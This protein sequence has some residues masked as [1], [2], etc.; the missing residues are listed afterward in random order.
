M[1][2]PFLAYKVLAAGAIH[3]IDGFKYA[4]VNGADFISVGMYDFQVR[5]DVNVTKKLFADK[6]PE[7]TRPW[8][9]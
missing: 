8:R 2:K 3:P 7:R 6:M 4:F 9:A 5:E 1:T